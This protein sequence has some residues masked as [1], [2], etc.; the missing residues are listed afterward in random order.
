MTQLRSLAI[1]P[2]QPPSGASA[3]IFQPHFGQTLSVLIIIGE[4]TGALLALNAAAIKSRSSSSIALGIATVWA[5]SS[6][7]N[8]W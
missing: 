5:I 2:G 8:V 6:R 4:P 1:G 7:N 3:G